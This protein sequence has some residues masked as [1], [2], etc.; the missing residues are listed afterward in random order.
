LE[1]ENPSGFQ[2]NVRPETI[3]LLEENK[4]GKLYDIGQS[5]DFFEYDPK[6][7]S[8]KSKNKQMGL[9][10]SRS[11]CTTKETKD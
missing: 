6:S 1:T 9:L 2:T 10:K 11:F 8:N 3:K 5:S 4:G 7:T